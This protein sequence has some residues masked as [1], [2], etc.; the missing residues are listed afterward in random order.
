L[1]P[2]TKQFNFK[3]SKELLAIDMTPKTKQNCLSLVI[4]KNDIYIVTDPNK[5]GPETAATSEVKLPE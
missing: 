5:F 4:Q 2:A 1:I 3:D